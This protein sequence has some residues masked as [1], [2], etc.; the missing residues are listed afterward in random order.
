MAADELTESSVVTQITPPE[1]GAGQLE[2]SRVATA[3]GDADS[4]GFIVAEE[5][6]LGHEPV[7]GDTDFSGR[8][9]A[10]VV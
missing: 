4:H 1:D 9:G 2:P 10:Q 5:A 6:M 8:T 3:E 7:S